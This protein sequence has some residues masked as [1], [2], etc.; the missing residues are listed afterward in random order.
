MTSRLSLISLAPLLASLF[1]LLLLATG[2]ARPVSEHALS[3][4]Q[5]GERVAAVVALLDDATE[6]SDTR[7]P[8]DGSL[9]DNSSGVD[10]LIHLA[11]TAR[12]WIPCVA[13]PPVMHVHEVGKRAPAQL[14]RPPERV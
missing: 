1:G 7:P 3:S 13:N 11:D 2:S 14:L 12:L 10:D 4:W 6:G 5:A 9:E 8:G